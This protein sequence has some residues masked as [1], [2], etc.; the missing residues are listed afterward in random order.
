MLIEIA[1]TNPTNPNKL[2]I[3]DARS[4]INAMANR[5]NKGGFENTKDYYTNSEICF[6]D[7][8]N[9]HSVRDAIT[10][11]Y[12][13]GLQPQVFT[14][15]TK[16]LTLLDNSNWLQIISKMFQAVNSI[17]DTIIQKK[18]NVLIHCTDGWDRTAQ[19]CSLAQIMLD[20]FYRTIKGF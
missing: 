1:R 19:L 9:I 8:E 15:T 18:C 20:P 14:N 2:V 5:I 11:V 17:L 3:F 6:C 13:M 10:K 7:I 4:Y 16:W 12:E